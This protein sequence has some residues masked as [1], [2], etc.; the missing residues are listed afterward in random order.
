MLYEVNPVWMNN[1]KSYHKILL[2]LAGKVKYN[3]MCFL[4]GV[5]RLKNLFYCPVHVFIAYIQRRRNSKGL[6]TT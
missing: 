1:Y 4:L 3:V 2:E 6:R 5:Q